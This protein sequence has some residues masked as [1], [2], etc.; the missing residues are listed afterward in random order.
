MD[1]AN[2]N[3]VIDI[4]LDRK[5]GGCEYSETYR[6]LEGPGSECGDCANEV[7]EGL[8]NDLE[9]TKCKTY[10]EFLGFKDHCI[11]C[12]FAIWHNKPMGH[13]KC[14]KTGKIFNTQLEKATS[15]IYCGKDGF[16]NGAF[17]ELYEDNK[18]QVEEK[19]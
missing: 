14:E 5:C 1:R 17:I 12:K 7:L 15:S 9:K 18:K 16:E 4:I 11:Y 2:K 8:E 3:T 10:W 19:D 13:Y 6:G